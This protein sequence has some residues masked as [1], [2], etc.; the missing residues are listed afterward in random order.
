MDDLDALG[1]Q[2]KDMDLDDLGGHGFGALIRLEDR[3]GRGGIH[4]FGAIGYGG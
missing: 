3:G 4:A 2:W 1:S